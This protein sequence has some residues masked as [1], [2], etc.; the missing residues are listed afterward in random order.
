MKKSNNGAEEAIRNNLNTMTEAVS[1][2]DAAKIA[3]VFTEDA[4]MKFPGMEPLEGKKA[5]EMAHQQMF[6]QGIAGLDLETRQIEAS[7]NLAYEVGSYKLSVG[8]GT[9][10]DHGSYLTVWKKNGDDWKIYRDVISS[11]QSAEG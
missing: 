8:D 2:G 5:V 6:K 11:A 7:G 1:E 10:I 4:F 9:T 3:S